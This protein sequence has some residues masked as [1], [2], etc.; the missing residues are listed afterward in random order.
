MT[1]TAI[2]T[3]FMNY[4]WK[5]YI[6]IFFMKQTSFVFIMLFPF[7]APNG[8]GWDEKIIPWEN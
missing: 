1:Q 3:C 2:G 8:I 4:Y 7:R 6:H 5:K